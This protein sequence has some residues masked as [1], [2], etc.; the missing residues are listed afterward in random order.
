M[1]QQDPSFK[2]AFTVDKPTI[3]GAK[4][5]QDGLE[6]HAAGPPAAE[7][8][9]RAVV[10]V[11]ATLGISVAVCG[12]AGAITSAGSDEDVEFKTIDK[13]SLATQRDHG[14]NFGAVSENLVF[15]GLTQA[16]FD[17]AM[18]PQLRADLTPARADLRPYYW[19]TLFEA[20][21]AVPRVP[22][23]GE[24]PEKPLLEVL[25][26][27]STPAMD[28]AHKR[29][30]GVAALFDKATPDTAVIVDLPGP[31][32]VA[33]AA[34]M[35]H[36]LEPVCTFDNWPHPRGVVPAHLTLAAAVY[37]Q[38]L[39]KRVRA[40]RPA[41]APPV[42]VLDRKRLAPY[43]DETTQ[44]DNRYV[45]KL[46]PASGLSQL[47]IKRVLYVVPNA[48]EVELD[49]LN[50]DF[51][52]YEKAGID[53]KLI[54]ASDFTP[55]APKSS[56]AG[57][58]PLAQGAE[59]DPY[60]YGGGPESSE[61]FWS[62]YGWESGTSGR[63]RTQPATTRTKSMYSGWAPAPRATMFG[64]STSAAGNADGTGSV[65]KA[66]K[67]AVGTVAVAIAATTGAI[68][69]TR[70]GAGRSSGVRSGGRSGSFGRSSGSG[71]G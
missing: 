23:A 27:V 71:W 43:T 5:W 19:P 38:P 44:F 7:V 46:P 9:R 66:S 52:D 24:S 36:R 50:Q 53:V 60:Y 12:V 64:S 51:V 15:D 48:G 55:G 63:P 25:T 20:P 47:G 68:L 67:V 2:Q 70:Y 11:L 33:M 17:K 32:S 58:V 49:D 18:V 4:W 57:A 54:P 30:K 69:G 13:N 45:A 26:P 62:D 28:I 1:S 37:Y 59:P 29:G 65:S 41:N 34:A 42:F 16:P 10:A 21:S 8:P 14:W 22:V 56:P 31:E 61:W 40:Q 6:A 39:F 3:V 35:A